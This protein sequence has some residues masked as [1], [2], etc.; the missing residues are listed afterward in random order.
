MKRLLL[1]SAL[2][3]G[4]ATS[5]M[6]QRDYQLY[7]FPTAIS[8]DFPTMGVLRRVSTNGQYAV[9]C[10]DALGFGHAFLW[11]RTEPDKLTILQ[12]VSPEDGGDRI[13][14]CDVSNDGTMVG[15]FEDTEKGLI[16]HPGYKTLTGEWVAL[17]VPEKYSEKSAKSDDYGQE[18]RAITA[19]GRYI[20]GNVEVVTGYKETIFGTSEVTLS[21]V[22]LWEKDGDGYVMKDFYEKAGAK[23]ASY[24]YQDGEMKQVADTVNYKSFFI[25]DI[26]DDGSLIVGLNV[27][28]CGG[29]NPAFFKDG[30]LMQIFNCDSE[31]YEDRNFN[32]GICSS[33]DANNNIYGYFMLNDAETMKYFVYTAEGKLEYLDALYVCADKDG[34]KFGMYEHGLYSAQDCCADGSVVVG[35]TVVNQGFGSAN[36]PGVLVDKNA[37]DGISRTNL[38]ADNVSVDYRPGGQLFVNGEYLR[39]SVYNAAGALVDEGQQGES[40]NLAGMPNGTYIVKVVSDHGC[41]SFKVLR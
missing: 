2:L 20:A 15:S 31:V 12:G 19:D 22:V 40:F 26:S 32:G 10:D 11:K 14:L 8:E 5:A 21:G 24:L 7:E 3:F 36:G 29:F 37:V 38:D 30:K 23:G 35:G 13:S 1:S 34:N 17:P 27:S 6:A 39:A 25:Y 41:K 18:A 16:P 4:V 33:V 28:D 9:G